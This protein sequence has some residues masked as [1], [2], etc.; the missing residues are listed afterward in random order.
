MAASPQRNRR[1]LAFRHVTLVG[2]RG[3]ILA[4]ADKAV[5]GPRTIGFTRA[6]FGRSVLPRLMARA[7]PSVTLLAGG[8]PRLRLRGLRLTF[9]SGDQRLPDGGWVCD[10]VIGTVNAVERMHRAAEVRYRR[11]KR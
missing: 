9:P 8:R 5:V 2:P 10:A 1:P 11:W 7:A 6:T 4:Y 3:L